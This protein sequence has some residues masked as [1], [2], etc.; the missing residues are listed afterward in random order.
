MADQNRSAQDVLEDLGIPTSDHEFLCRLFASENPFPGLSGAELGPNT[1]L[2]HNLNN[3]A[4]GQLSIAT[5]PATNLQVPGHSSYYGDEWVSLISQESITL[6]SELRG[7]VV[8]PEDIRRP[9]SNEP[10][11]SSIYD[12]DR[13]ESN[14]Q[15]VPATPGPPSTPKIPGIRQTTLSSAL[16][17]IETVDNLIS[18]FPRPPSSDSPREKQAISE[19]VPGKQQV[20]T[21][22]NTKANNSTPD[23]SRHVNGPIIF[24][25]SSA[26]LDTDI[27]DIGDQ[28]PSIPQRHKKQSLPARRNQT[29]YHGRINP[30][31]CHPVRADPSQIH[32]SFSFD[33]LDIPGAVLSPSTSSTPIRTPL[34]NFTPPNLRTSPVASIDPDIRH[35]QFV[36]LNS[37]ASVQPSVKSHTS[38]ATYALFPKPYPLP[39]SSLNSTSRRIPPNQPHCEATDHRYYRKV[40]FPSHVA[41]SS[42][43][44]DRN[45]TRPEQ[46]G[47]GCLKLLKPRSWTCIT[48]LCS[49]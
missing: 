28:S 21:E 31:R 45:P 2:D 16:S 46:E 9:E 4:S 5:H 10:P 29:E 11:G 18:S 1:T 42:R 23:T 36:G 40:P 49:R 26:L 43:S 44:L 41:Q 48:S 20:L 35:T 6:L 13:G 15:L 8:L 39:Q 7:L 27:V 24:G 37:P 17:N 47:C 38:R 34:R 12:S 30:L 25:D 33:T 3:R 22:S 32:G 19:I 14:H